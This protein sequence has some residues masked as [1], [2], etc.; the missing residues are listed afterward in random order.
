MSRSPELFHTIVQVPPGPPWVQQRAAE[1]AAELEAPLALEALEIAI[2]RLQ[3]WKSNAPARLA[4]GYLRA[5][6][7]AVERR[8]S[9]NVEGQEVAF[10]FR[11][12]TWRA[13]GRRR[14][15]L[16]LS[17]M[18]LALASLT[19]AGVKW[20]SIREA[21]TVAIE[22]RALAARRAIAAVKQEQAVARHL[23]LM[24]RSD[25]GGRSGLQVAEDL[26][27]LSAQR[28][29][30]LALTAVTWRREGLEI[31]SGQAPMV[32]AENLGPGRWRLVAPKTA[33]APPSTSGSE[34]WR[35]SMRRPQP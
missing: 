23:T 10:V 5:S 9:I 11:S 15:V 17:L 4:I 14:R 1:V 7:D 25:L 24:G 29:P 21:A 35:P 13:Q 16:V 19:A 12:R 3:P 28:R 31:E 20:L 22:A 26:A 6:D 8:H 2:V 18:L 32:G 33:P 34:R 30:G 27:W